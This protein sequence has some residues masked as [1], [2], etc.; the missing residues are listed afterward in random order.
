MGGGG[1]QTDITGQGSERGNAGIV[2]IEGSPCEGPEKSFEGVVSSRVILRTN[3]K[4]G[5]NCYHPSEN[6]S[7]AGDLYRLGAG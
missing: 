6:P 5:E 3:T 2:A 1:G 4:T 7:P